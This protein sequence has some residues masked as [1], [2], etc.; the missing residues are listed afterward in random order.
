MS[1]PIPTL[2]LLK[3]G[4]IANW[5]IECDVASCL[6]ASTIYCDQCLAFVCDDHQAPHA[7]KS[8]PIFTKENYKSMM[9]FFGAVFPYSLEQRHL[10]DETKQCH[11]YYD[12][13]TNQLASGPKFNLSAN[14]PIVS[15]F[16]N[17]GSGKSTLL[18]GCLNMSAAAAATTSAMPVPEFEHHHHACTYGLVAYETPTHIFLDSQGFGGSIHPS[19]RPD[20][21]PNF[22]D[23]FEKITTE[24]KA[25]DRTHLKHMYQSSRVL[26]FVA[27]SIAKCAM[28]NQLYE[29][30]DDLPEPE[31]GALRPILIVVHNQTT[32]LAS[33]AIIT[34]Q[35]DI[36][37]KYF[38]SVS[39]HTLGVVPYSEPSMTQLND[40]YQAFQQLHTSIEKAAIGLD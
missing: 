38:S 23:T 7:A 36:F 21:D 3:R 14:K 13:K 15:F 35:I 30:I 22:K 39:L 8:H 24:G 5:L 32:F 12:A 31:E 37:A 2:S 18:R 1:L 28:F 27:L 17:A 9:R 4:P 19:M 26:V 34:A 40:F 10:D 6:A 29:M 25:T 20:R 16:G 11:A 33:P